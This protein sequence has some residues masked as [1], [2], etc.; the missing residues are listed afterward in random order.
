MFNSSKILAPA[1]NVSWPMLKWVLEQGQSMIQWLLYQQHQTEYFLGLLPSSQ[2]VAEHQWPSQPTKKKQQFSRQIECSNWIKHKSRY[3]S[4]LS[5]C[6][7]KPTPL[8]ISSKQFSMELCSE[9]F[10]L[11]S[12]SPTNSLEAWKLFLRCLQRSPTKPISASRL[13]DLICMAKDVA[14]WTTYDLSWGSFI[15]FLWS[16]WCITEARI[17][18]WFPEEKV[19]KITMRKKSKVLNCNHT[20]KINIQSLLLIRSPKLHTVMKVKYGNMITDD[21]S[22][23]LSV[24]NNSDR[25]GM[26][27]QYLCS[28]WSR[29]C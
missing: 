17:N 10:K 18:R 19:R 12:C 24:N 4:L 26:R 14:T 6:I 13:P 29:S 23:D 11:S 3:G 1:A 15:T 20:W 21:T 9:I 25:N 5:M 27:K 8:A 28:P 16:R 2:T 22:N 7:H